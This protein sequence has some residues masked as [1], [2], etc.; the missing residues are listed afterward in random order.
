[1]MY[2]LH[3]MITF[4]PT[5]AKQLFPRVPF[6][7]RFENVHVPSDPARTT[8]VSRAFRKLVVMQWAGSNEISYAFGTL[9][10]DSDKI[11]ALC[12]EHRLG[13]LEVKPDVGPNT[14]LIPP[15]RT[16]VCAEVGMTRVNGNARNLGWSQ[17][18]S[19]SPSS[20]ISIRPR[21][22]RLS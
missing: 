13:L 17:M 8:W 9:L 7:T 11:I 20:A 10:R 3:P 12:K 19:S 21:V 18:I 5:I 1:M 4:I 2:Q 22:L 6:V 14:A 16:C 15:L